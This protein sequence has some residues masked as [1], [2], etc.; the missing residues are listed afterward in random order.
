MW[1]GLGWL[2]LGWVVCDWVGL[3]VIGWVGVAVS[4]CSCNEGI[5]LF[6]YTCPSL[7]FGLIALIEGVSIVFL[8]DYVVAISEYI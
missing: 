5:T 1:F 7:F 8:L 2:G 4:G 3:S 6:R